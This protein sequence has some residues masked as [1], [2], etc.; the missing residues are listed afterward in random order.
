MKGSYT[1]YFS[2]ILGHDMGIMSYG[3][4]GMPCIVFPS[5]DGN[6]LDFEG[7]GMLEPCE[8]WLSQGK[9][10]L[11]CVDS[12]DKHTWSAYH[13]PPRERIQHHEVW[14]RHITEEV[15]PFVHQNSGWQDRLMTLGCSMGATH[16]ANA[17]LRRPDIFQILI[18]LS[19]AYDA[20]WLMAGYM[21]DLVYLNSPVDNLAGMP[22][23]HPYIQ[24]FNNSKII[25]CCGQGAW[26]D[27]M[28]RSLGILRE[29][30]QRKGINAWVDIWG[31]DVNHDWDWWRK[32]LHYFLGKV[33]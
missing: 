25:F 14:V 26:E 5:Q 3:H 31:F 20:A 11:Y 22:E 6:C 15:V 17:L 19:G 33:L 24:Q 9:L 28:L 27:E 18:A 29:Q 12:L 23:D 30:M 4:G 32:Q 7:F 2:Q 10:R 13:L 16:A 1:K 21:D 8:P